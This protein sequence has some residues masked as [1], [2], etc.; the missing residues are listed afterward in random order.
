MNFG[1]KKS[2]LTFADFKVGDIVLT[3]DGNLC[4]VHS[5]GSETIFVVDIR[6]PKVGTQYC[7]VPDM[8]EW[9]R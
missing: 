5:I 2:K 6:E 9:P 3:Y 4:K 7:V 8:L 1:Y